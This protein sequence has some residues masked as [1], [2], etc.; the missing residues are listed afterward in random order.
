MTGSRD[1][2]GYCLHTG[3]IFDRKDKK[4]E[5]D[6]SMTKCTRCLSWYHDDCVNLTKSTNTENWS[7][8][9]CKNLPT[10]VFQLLET[11]NCLVI[12]I[13]DLQ[14]KITVS[15]SSLD[16]VIIKCDKLLKENESLKKSVANLQNELRL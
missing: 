4:K 9:P 16:S 11:V 15:Q 8:T 5:K 14:Q 6:I 7:C 10:N 12:I 2:L 1:Q 3:C 13:N